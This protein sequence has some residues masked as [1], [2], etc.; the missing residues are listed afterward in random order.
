MELTIESV[1]NA[2][3]RGDAGANAQ[4]IYWDDELPSF[5]LR[6]YPSGTKSWVIG[7]WAGRRKRLMTLAPTHKLALRE[8]RRRAKVRLGEAAGGVD[9]QRER[10]RAR[11]AATVG[12]LC[13]RY[14]DEHARP[15]KKARSVTTDEQLI[16]DY[17]RPRLGA[18]QV[19]LVDGND[20]ARLHHSMKGTPVQANRVLA[21]VSKMFS[22][23]ERWGQR[24][25]RSNPV[26]AVERFPE[27]P[28][29]GRLDYSQLGALGKAL[30]AGEQAGES[31]F[32][33]A[34]IRLLALT[35][36]RRNEVLGAQCQ[37]LDRRSGVLRLP[38]SKTGGRLVYLGPAAWSV[39]D[40]LPT[41]EGNPYVIPGQRPGAHL[42][43]LHKPWHR[44][45]K[46]AGLVGSGLRPH[47]L[48]HTFASVAGDMGMSPVLIAGLLGHRG[49][50]RVAGVG[51]WST[52]EG[53]VS[54]GDQALR[55]AAE[56]VSSRIAAAL[57]GK[58]GR[59]VHMRPRRRSVG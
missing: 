39:V 53:Y 4:C 40:T 8:A 38:D 45:L 23:A 20:V 31:P 18:H 5:G 10:Q 21:L 24:A 47:D 50:A 19:E 9:P 15:K 1:E 43:N 22:L 48:R 25:P 34:A 37:W 42:N 30:T 6:V 51:G 2:K 52:T 49:W 32:G 54:P 35:G 56:R 12:E 3:Y 26:R 55:D 14:L 27:K 36:A 7:Y 16:R 44:A 41:L 59:V 58:A 46:R 29:H 57:A 17:V 13:D 11:Q 28:T 33:L